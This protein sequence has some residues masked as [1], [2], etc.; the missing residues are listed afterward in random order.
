MNRFTPH[1]DRLIDLALEEDVAGG[2]ITTCAT[3]DAQT[4]GEA[5]VVAKED[6]VVAGL[7]PF[8]RVFERLDPSLEIHPEV[9]DGQRAQAGEVVVRLS[10]NA[11]SLLVGERP[12]LNFLMRLSGIATLTQQL[13]LAL[14]DHPNTRLIDTRKTTPGWRTLEKEAVLA[15]G[16]R[17]HRAGLFDGILIKDNHIAA[18]GGIRSAVERARAHAHHLLKVEVETTNLDEV[19]QALEAGAEV[20]ML[21][22]MNDELL[23][24]AVEKVRAHEAKTQQK[25]WLEASGNMHLERLPTVGALG[26][27]LVSV[28]ALTHGARSVDLSMKLRLAA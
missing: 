4:Q 5:R 9:K 15:G 18:A 2:D 22:N 24:A 3:V 19:A 27:D 21:D 7:V 13:S 17:N 23:A 10:G 1:L 12:A 25:I 8:M 26:I 6:L 11:R 28:G 14:A 16:G 20:L